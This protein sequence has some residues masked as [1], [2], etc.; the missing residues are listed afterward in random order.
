MEKRVNIDITIL[1]FLYARYKQFIIPAVVILV[2]FILLIT[3]IMPQLKALFALSN[4]AK[5]DSNRIVVL[6]NNLNLLS[7]LSDS[8]LDSQLQI[9]SI[10]LPTNKDFIGVINAIS[11]AAS[12][13]GANVSEF[14]LQI[15]DLSQAPTDTGKF[16]SLS[17]NLS[18]N[19]STNDVN[20]FIKALYTTFPLS[21]VTSVNIGD[22]VSTVAINF[23]HK[24]LPPV[25]YNDSTPIN[26]IP[27]SGL[28]RIN[29]LYNFNYN[30]SSSS[31]S[32]SSL[33]SGLV[34]PL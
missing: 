21:E 28:K 1:K 14:Q 10:A 27:N 19:G 5:K 26:P 30:F 15:G 12:F 17:L 24:P 6:K 18:V 2:C 4:D 9:V 32:V 11:Y 34:N 16:S 7:S 25:A 3:F 8:A 22:T 29:D 33:S 13:T 23:Y 31:E 20:K